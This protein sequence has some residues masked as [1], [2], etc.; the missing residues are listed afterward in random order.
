MG[1]V[2]SAEDSRLG[3]RVALKTLGESPNADARDRLW[4][5]ARSAAALSHPGICQVYDVVEQD[6]EL[7]VAMELL[8]GQGLDQRMKG[9]R[10][11]VEEAVRIAIEILSPLGALHARGVVH[12]DLKPSNVFLTPHGTKILD[13]GIAREV[14]APADTQL[15]REGAIMGTPHY[16][17]PEQWRAAGLGPRS[18]LFACGALLYEMLAGDYAFPG[19]DPIAVF[20]ACAFE[21]PPPLTGAPGIDAVDAVVRRSIAKDPEERPANAAEMAAQLEEALARMTSLQT[22]PGGRTPPVQRRAETVRR[23]IALP[24]RTLRPDPDLDFLAASLPEA[25]GGALSGLQ[26]LVVRSGRLAPR[27]HAEDGSLDFKKLASDVEVDYALAG[28]LMS[29][30]SRLRLS[31][32]LLQVP[33]GTVVWSLTE[34]VAVEDL[35]GV[36][37]DLAEKVVR[38]IAIPLSDQEEAWVH[39][40]VSASPRAYEFYLRAL[41]AIS[42][43]KSPADVLAV[44]DMLRAAVDEDPGFTP[45]RAQYARACRVI[46]KYRFGDQAEHVRIATQQFRIAFAADP[47]SPLL[48]Y[49][50]TYHQIEDLRDPLGAMLRLLQQVRGKTTAAELW[51]GLV[52]ACRFCGLY[53]AS[54]AAHRRARAL[55]PKISTSIEF[56]HL[57]RGDFEEAEKAMPE[58]QP[59]SGLFRS[60]AIALQG[61]EAR[62]IQMVR[63]DGS[64]GVWAVFGDAAA[65]MME[66]NVE[67]A[68][69]SI[70]EAYEA[71]MPDP[72]AIFF[73]AR[74]AARGGLVEFAL[75][76]IDAAVDRGFNCVL[77]LERGPWVTRVSGEPRYQEALERARVARAEAIVEFRAAGGEEIL[78]VVEP[79]HAR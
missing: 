8:E 57:Q 21:Q 69:R 39:R 53:D 73:F 59:D 29:V 27:A 71:G 20:H 46:A 42:I 65:D 25:I 34:D 51:A 23:F 26:H 60:L 61:D 30:G 41:H 75:D 45:A 13:F 68:E 44:R 76:L 35:F 50:Y 48:H 4:R 22:D 47:E 62:A 5:E 72:E 55:D 37:D 31:A 6:G 19:D 1:V 64:R 7:W 36:Q 52:P 77:G 11:S 70:R 10:F 38:G 2:Y 17:A 43:S 24:F 49:L 58:D 63:S 16:M 15:T 9:D 28:T 32:E 18:D 56:T 66:G 78:G 67:A 12:R 79:V 74:V 3:R 14:E 40:N 54:L 33:A